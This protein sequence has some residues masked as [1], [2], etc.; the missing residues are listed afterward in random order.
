[1]YVKAGRIR[2]QGRTPASDY[3]AWEVDIKTGKETRLTNFEYMY[4]SS[5]CYFPDDESFLYHAEGPF[6]FPGLKFPKNAEGRFK[7]A[8][9][10]LA[11]IGEEAH[12]GKFI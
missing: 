11:T 7:D 12:R 3:D 10:A 2:K 1:M 5:V 6:A 8:K 9:A 4:M